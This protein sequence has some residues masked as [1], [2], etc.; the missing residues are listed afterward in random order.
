[1]AWDS[2]TKY[3]LHCNGIDGSTTFIDEIGHI[4]TPHG[5]VQI[6]TAQYVFGGASGLFDGTGDYLST[7]DHPDLQF[8]SGDFTI[9]FR[10]R[11]SSASG[12]IALFGRY[13]A[14]N[15]G[16]ISYYDGS[17]LHFAYSTNGT[18][19][20]DTAR[21]WTATLNQWYH[22][23][24][25]RNGTVVKLFVDGIQLGTDISIGTDSIYSTSVDFG[26]G[27]DPNYDGMYFN[28]WM[29]EFRIS[30]G[31]ARWT[32]NFTPPTSEYS[33]YNKETITS[34][35]YFYTPPEETILS[36]AHFYVPQET[37]LSDATFV[38]EEIYDVNQK[39]TMV[40]QALYNI[41]NKISTVKRV[42]SNIYKKKRIV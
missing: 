42:L 23:A 18:N 32:S 19:A 38:E 17:G 24:V 29:D 41:N 20:I 5:N 25:V 7:V 2:Y 27:A 22:I 8:G 11:F 35:A 15:R 31:I 13:Q 37:I 12:A 34:D 9:D 36:D 21:T 3:V 33:E 30:K 1:M 40:K 28:G 10:A 16:I 39:F 4:I 6:D 26:F 14:P